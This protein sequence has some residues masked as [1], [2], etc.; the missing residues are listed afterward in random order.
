MGSGLLAK[1]IDNAPHDYLRT[2]LYRLDLPLAV[3]MPKLVAV[4]A[5]DALHSELEGFGMAIKRINR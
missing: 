3:V 4:E 2:S 1:H 5:L